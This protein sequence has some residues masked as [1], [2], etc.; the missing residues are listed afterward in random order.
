[1]IRKIDK[2]KIIKQYMKNVSEAGV[3]CLDARKRIFDAIVEQPGIC[4]RELERTLNISIGQLTYHLPILVKSG[5]I[6]EESDEHFRR[7]FHFGIDRKGV[8]LISFFRRDAVKR[9][10][11]VFISKKEVT[12]KDLSQDLGITPSTANWHIKR[13]RAN[14]LVHEKKKGNKTYYS[15][16]DIEAIKYIYKI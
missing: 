1:M 13:M 10:I 9:V 8:K 15:L 11:P 3:L 5:L 16:K 2:W 6:V 14:G 4:I 7:F 12:N